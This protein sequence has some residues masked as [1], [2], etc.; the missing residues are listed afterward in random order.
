[1]KDGITRFRER[2]FRNAI[3]HFE[4]ILSIDRKDKAANIHL[5]RSIYFHNHGVPPDWE[6]V[7][8]LNEK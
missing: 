2:D 4:E 5:Q 6:G 3:K 8:A 7:S 1:M